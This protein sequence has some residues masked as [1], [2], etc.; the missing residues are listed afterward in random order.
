MRI[1]GA[2]SGAK[3]EARRPWETGTNGLQRHDT[4]ALRMSLPLEFGIGAGSALGRQIHATALR[5]DFGSRQALARPYRMEWGQDAVK[6]LVPG[7]CARVARR[8]TTMDS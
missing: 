2:S 8:S 6:G 3:M 4:A 5:P 7:V 1:G